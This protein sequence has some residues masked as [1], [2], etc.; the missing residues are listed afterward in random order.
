MIKLHHKNGKQSVVQK[1][2]TMQ[3]H[4]NT[5]TILLLYKT[6]TNHTINNH[7]ICPKESSK[8][9]KLR[10]TKQKSTTASF[11]SHLNTRLHLEGEQIETKI[12]NFK[13]D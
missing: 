2:Y 1:P 4:I 3:S 11:T 9:M 13:L 8:K 6:L 7:S 12:R 10:V 5:A